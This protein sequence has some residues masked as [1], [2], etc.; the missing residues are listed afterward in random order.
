MKVLSSV[1]KQPHLPSIFTPQN[2]IGLLLVVIGWVLNSNWSGFC[3]K[4]NWQPWF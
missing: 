3:Y 4:K 2:A 1:A